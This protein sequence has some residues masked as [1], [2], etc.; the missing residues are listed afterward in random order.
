MC[1]G[2]FQR[3]QDHKGCNSQEAFTDM[4]RWEWGMNTYALV[5]DCPGSELTLGFVSFDNFK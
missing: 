2:D 1:A 4:E 5:S 3:G